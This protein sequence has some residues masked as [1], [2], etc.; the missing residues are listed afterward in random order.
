MSDK[1]C[2]LCRFV[3]ITRM[4]GDY[5]PP[6]DDYICRRFPPVMVEPTMNRG[7]N[8]WGQWP[9]VN[10]FDWCGEWKEKTP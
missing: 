9:R 4:P 6:R 3:Q 7:V 5:V 2:A 8:T 1:T 10:M